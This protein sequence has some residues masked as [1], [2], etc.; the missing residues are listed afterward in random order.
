MQTGKLRSRAPILPGLLIFFFAASCGSISPPTGTSATTPTS[1]TTCTQIPLAVGSP[2]GTLKSVNGKTLLII[3][4]SGKTIQVIY[5]AT[6]HFVRE[7]LVTATVLQKGQ[8]VSVEVI[9]NPDRTY[10]ARIVTLITPTTPGAPP[11]GTFPSRG[12]HAACPHPTRAVNSRAGTLTITGSVDQLNGNKLTVITESKQAY[13]V[14]LTGTTQIVHAVP[15]SAS[16]LHAGEAV[17]VV[18]TQ[19]AQGKLVAGQVTILVSLPQSATST[20]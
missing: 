14:T 4:Q 20:P 2:E 9:Q 1:A 17:S 12:E 13:T 6:T 18:S 8:S 7:T 10:T 3:D 15:A 16:A 5:T 19:Q 11:L